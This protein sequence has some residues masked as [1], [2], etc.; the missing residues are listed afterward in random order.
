M[1]LTFARKKSAPFR[2]RVYQALLY[3]YAR[4]QG[5]V[6]NGLSRSQLDGERVHELRLSL[7]RLRAV[8]DLMDLSGYEMEKADD[9]L[10]VWNQEL[11][12]LRDEAII[13]A[14][15][16]KNAPPERTKGANAQT[17]LARKFSNGRARRI[18]ANTVRV[19]ELIIKLGEKLAR[20]RGNRG[21]GLDAERAIK[22]SY[23]LTRDAWEKAAKSSKAKDL[24]QFRKRAKHLMY[25]LEACASPRDETAQIQ[26]ELRTLTRH[27]GKLNDLFIIGDYF[28]NEDATIPHR[29]RAFQ[30][31]R[32]A[33]KRE[34]LAVDKAATAFLSVKPKDFVERLFH[35]ESEWIEN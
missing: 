18:R 3:S 22:E 13:Q 21:E 12:A 7:K 6:W 26:A 15:L 20:H 1:N 29:K 4:T 35:V 17:P 10:R 11:G 24:H 31:L 9:K 5:A 27:L 32:R 25:Q 2:H 8:V 23:K 28:E 16:A 34:R 14:W 30:I 33:Q 19:K